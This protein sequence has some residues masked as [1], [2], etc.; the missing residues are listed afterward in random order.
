MSGGPRGKWMIEHRR[1]GTEQASC[2]GA[3]HLPFQLVLPTF[4]Q[5]MTL[6]VQFM[7]AINQEKPH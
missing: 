1:P 7:I 4:K 3:A 6:R 2:G 5:A